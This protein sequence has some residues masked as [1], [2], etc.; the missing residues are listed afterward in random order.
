MSEVT[1]Y[2]SDDTDAPILSAYTVD[3]QGTYLELLKAILI[4]G[5]GSKAAAGWTLEA[6][7]I[8]AN[9]VMIIRNS[10]TTGTGRYYRIQDN[11][12]YDDTLGKGGTFS[13]AAYV[14]GCESFSDVNTTIG[15]FPNL[16]G[17]PNP[18]TG[19]TTYEGVSHF[20][21][22]N[23]SSTY[24]VQSWIAIADERTIQIIINMVASKPNL[25]DMDDTYNNNWFTLGDVQ[26][27]NNTVNQNAA[28]INGNGF[29]STLSTR[30]KGASGA[31]NT[32]K[33]MNRGYQGNIG[34]IEIGYS[35]VYLPGGGGNIAPTC[36]TTDDG[37]YMYPNQV[38][39]G[40]SYSYIYIYEDVSALENTD[41]LTTDMETV[42]A[43]HRGVLTLDHRI[44]NGD[45]TD[46]VGDWL[47]TLTIN[48][49]DYIILHA[50]TS[51]LDCILLFQ[52]S[53][54]M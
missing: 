16:T 7:D 24:A 1:V 25:I 20:K 46:G 5:Y 3:G 50:N 43:V 14:R 41:A 15:N 32:Y 30:V 38:I 2:R 29:Y 34:A 13:H 23:S 35:T 18:E 21:G 33:W 54:D 17:D 10:P 40:L 26:P 9:G 51:T 39:G 42:Q 27:L 28:F 37:K 8:T 45:F 12:Y 52:I 53:G 48:G 4:D 11:G 19:T 49:K 6:D 44:N 47:D 22:A 36:V 31:V